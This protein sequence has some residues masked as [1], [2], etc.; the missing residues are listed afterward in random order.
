MDSV[1]LHVD[2]SADGIMINN[3]DSDGISND[4]DVVK[5]G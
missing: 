5:F 3:D 2:L 4:D 1:P